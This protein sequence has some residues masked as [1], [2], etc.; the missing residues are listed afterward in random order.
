M[1]KPMILYKGRV[2][3]NLKQEPSLFFFSLM[4]TGFKR[5]LTESDLW[6]LQSTHRVEKLQQRFEKYWNIELAKK[7][8]YASSFV[9]H[10]LLITH[11]VLNWKSNIYSIS[12]YG[13]FSDTVLRWFWNFLLSI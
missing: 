1:H 9:F 7:E 10:L 2:V 4:V 11:I 6:E 8:K 12:E 13:K 5:P 3:G